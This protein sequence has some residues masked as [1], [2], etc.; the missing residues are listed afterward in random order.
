MKGHFPP[1]E[2]ARSAVPYS[3]GGSVIMVRGRDTP[4]GG[5]IGALY[6]IVG[7]ALIITH[8]HH[9][10]NSLAATHFIH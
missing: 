2:H 4:Q 9:I 3:L 10:R 5:S 1:F 8:S 6:A 7:R